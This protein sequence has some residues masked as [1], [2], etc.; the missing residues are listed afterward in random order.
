MKSL[1]AGI[2]RRY[3]IT[4]DK[5]PQIF[6][7]LC[8]QA[9]MNLMCQTTGYAGMCAQV[10]EFCYCRESAGVAQNLYWILTRY[11]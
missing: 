6:S 5:V 8:R 7:F 10:I 9:G 1:V 11:E 3:A 2:P 4:L